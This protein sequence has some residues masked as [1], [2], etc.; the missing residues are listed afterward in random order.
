M[1]WLWQL[2]HNQTETLTVETKYLHYP[3]TNNFDSQGP[4]PGQAAGVW[5]SLDSTPL[6][7]FTKPDQKPIFST[8]VVDI[9][10]SLGYTYGPGSFS[11]LV[12]QPRLGAPL[13]EPQPG[14]QPA[15]LAVSGI[16]RAA[17]SGSFVVSA[18]GTVGGK[19]QLL[20]VESVLSRQHTQ[21]CANCQTHLNVRS[22]L[23]LHGLHNDAA[24]DDANIEVKV[25]T[26]KKPEGK[27]D[28][29]GLKWK[30]FVHAA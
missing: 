6:E 11:D 26:H 29:P 22:F 21:G 27:T 3:G 23:P 19:R 15:T 28:H 9:E 13:A 30:P 17:I 16:N 1:F 20:G 7:P 10:G 2:K 24:I 4:T 8:D 25:H 18:T 5:L 14:A 12:E